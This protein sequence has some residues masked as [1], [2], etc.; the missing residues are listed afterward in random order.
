MPQIDASLDSVEHLLGELLEVSK[1][2]S[3]VTTPV[4]TDFRLA[5]VLGPLGAEFARW[6]PAS[7][8]FHRVPTSVAVRSDPALLRRILQNFLA[9]AFRYTD[10][11]GVLIGCRRRRGGRVAVEVWDTGP[12]IP[13]DKL[14]EIFRE[15]HR[16][17]GGR[18]DRGEGLGL[19]LAI[20]ERL[21]GLMGHPVSVRSRPGRGQRLLGRAAAGGGS[22]GGRRPPPPRARAGSSTARWWPS[23]RT[24][25][26]SRRR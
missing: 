4:F 24:S 18:T 25:R 21:S 2:D 10:R 11:G 20:V 1:L 8:R 14:R 23:S 3:G 17:P 22:G 5:D 6:R 16:L 7:L 19:G 13:E 12:G 9:N 26:R 15:F